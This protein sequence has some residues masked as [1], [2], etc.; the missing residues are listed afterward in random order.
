MIITTPTGDSDHQVPKN[1]GSSASDATPTSQVADPSRRRMMRQAFSSVAALALMGAL[2]PMELLTSANAAPMPATEPGRGTTGAVRPFQINVAQP[3]LDD[4]Q[5]RLARTRYPDEVEGAAWDYGTNREYL[6]QLIAYWRTGYN[7]RAQE[8]R[9]NEFPQ[10]MAEVDGVDLHFLHIKGKGPNPMPLLLTHGWPDSFF[11]F[12]KLIPYLTDPAKYGG[13]AEDAFTVVVPDIPGFGWSQKPTHPGTDTERAADLFALLMTQTLGYSRFAAHGGDFGAS[14]SEQL[15][16]RHPES[17]LAIHLLNVPPQHAQ[18]AKPQGLS[19]VERA[20]LLQVAAWGKKEGAFTT[21]QNSKPQTLG[22]GLND[23]P[24][25]LCAWIV[26]KFYGWSDQGPNHQLPFTRDELL[27]NVMIYWVT[28]TI[29]SSE[30]F[31]FEKARKP[32]LEL[33]YVRVPT[34]F[35]SFVNDI[36]PA[37]RT[38]AERFFNVQRWTEMPHGGHFAALEVPGALAAQLREFF[39][40]FRQI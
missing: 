40:P 4:L 38:F 35:A 23:S 8:A 16:L 9:L 21:I 11:R 18:T 1:S 17:L 31:Y 37:P 33:T 39:H 6:Q 28:Q 20:Y 24:A 26:E 14:I 13:R 15:A 25:G 12:V 29:T 3:V 36:I 30:R 10:F 5:G 2:D 34:G 27:T 32:T 19:A 7:W 22:Y